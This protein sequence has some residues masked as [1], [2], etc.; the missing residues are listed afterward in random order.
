MS[1]NPNDDVTTVAIE[2]EPGSVYFKIAD[3][4]PDPSRIEFFLRRAIEEW[5]I[6]HPQ[7]GIAKVRSFVHEGVMAGIH[8][9]FR[10][11]SELPDEVSEEEGSLPGSA[12]P[13]EVHGLIS[14]SFSREY[15]EAVI[16]SAFEILPSYQDR[17]GTLVMINR[18]RV[19]I[20][21]DKQAGRGAVI[22]VDFI[23]QVV[24]GP[25]KDK[26]LGW[27]IHP[28]TPFY[29]MHIEGSWFADADLAADRLDLLGHPDRAHPPFA[30]LFE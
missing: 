3:P 4:K 28:A 19:A 17:K 1:S 24:A 8:V 18:R 20:V 22:P 14:Q 30:D 13:I 12:M 29:V 6:A 15:I 5:L 21:I 7:L 25:V 23:E 9:W 16:G 10:P 2:L 26:L 11:V 27:L